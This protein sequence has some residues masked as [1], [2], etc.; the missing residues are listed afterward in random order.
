MNKIQLG[1]ISDIPIGRKGLNVKV[2]NNTHEFTNVGV[3]L[4]KSISKSAYQSYKL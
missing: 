1:L 3:A 4:G 2:D